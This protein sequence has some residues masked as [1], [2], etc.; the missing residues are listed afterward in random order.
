MR[1]SYP[2]CFILPVALALAGCGS[3]GQA[4]EET[5]DEAIAE[6]ALTASAR[7]LVGEYA[8]DEDTYATELNLKDDGTFTA[9][10]NPRVVGVTLACVR[11]PCLAQGDG[12]WNI[13]ASGRL[14]LKVK[15]LTGT[16]E[17][18]SVTFKHRLVRGII[19]MLYLERATRS[20]GE[21]MFRGR[22][23][24][25]P[26]C[27]ATLCSPGSHCVERS[28]GRAQCVPDL[29]PTGPCANK[30]CGA[31]CRLCNGRPGCVETAVPKFC[32]PEGECRS[33]MPTA[34]E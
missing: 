25:G 20:E 27:R 34:C 13:N 15:N 3:E 2:A 1:I 26:G 29:P 21:Q 28:D 19:P 11:A 12:T 23:D 18:R 4:P 9:K 6:G 8:S 24:A 16:T 17:T 10:F 31:S 14:A 33:S 5:E 32:S 22:A 7:S 30:P